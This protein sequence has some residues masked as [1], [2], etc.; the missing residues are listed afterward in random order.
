MCSQEHRQ[1]TI[2]VYMTYVCGGA[3]IISILSVC[4]CQSIQQTT[5]YVIHVS[6]VEQ[7]SLEY[8]VSAKSMCKTNVVVYIIYVPTVEEDRVSLNTASAKSMEKIIVVLVYMINGHTAEAA[9]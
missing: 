2:V 4:Q 6:M 3:G 5:V 8:T 1:E 7:S 9:G